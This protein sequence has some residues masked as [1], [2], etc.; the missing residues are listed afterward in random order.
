MKLTIGE[1]IKSLR[2]KHHITQEQLA[3]L[4]G[5]STQSV[6]RWEIGA[7]YPDIELLPS[8]A[9]YFG[10][11]LDSLMGMDELRSSSRKNSIYTA[12][13]D[14]ER[15]GDWQAAVQIFTEALHTY[16]GDESLTA[17]LALALTQTGETEKAIAL[18]EAVLDSS[19]NEKLRSTV[20]ANLCFLYKSAGLTEKAAAMARTLPHIW[21]SRE[22]LLPAIVQAD[23][24]AETLDRS[25]NIALQIM[26]DAVQN[27]NILFSLGYKPEPSVDISPLKDLLIP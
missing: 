25:L 9:N 1:N 15:T 19:S 12:A 22:M 26:R 4:L 23:D 13:F 5:V 16:P 18:S 2:H 27:K 17:E 20:R 24:R 8:I 10:V 6:S 14:R 7:C 3:D 11:T 21:E